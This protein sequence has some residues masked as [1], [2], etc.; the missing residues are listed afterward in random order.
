MLPVFIII[1]CGAPSSPADAM[2]RRPGP[3]PLVFAKRDAALLARIVES[4]PLQGVRSGSA[5]LVTDGR[6][7]VVQDDVQAIALV[8]VKTRAVETRALAGSGEAQAKADK[9]DFEA[10][11]SAPDGSLRLVGSGSTPQRRKIARL[12]PDGSDA[13]LI[14]AGTLYDAIQVRIGSMPNI[15]GAVP[16]GDWVR[17]LHRGAGGGRSATVDVARA[18][19]DGGEPTLGAARFYDLGRIGQVPLTLTDAAPLAGR[20]LLYLAVA[21]ET[22]DA[23]ADGPV[24]GA[25]LGVLDDSSARWTPLLEKDGAPSVRKVE[26]VALDADAR[27]GWLVTDADDPER[28]AELL[29]FRLEGSW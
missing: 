9:P 20:R 17:R 23:V 21:E 25:A 29:R 12:A 26:G 22:P 7:V 11:F 13:R 14:E 19:F 1:L 4:W 18:T 8:D 27:G 2:Q 28:P 10:A 16:L 24:H 15:E 6:L 5:L 3:V